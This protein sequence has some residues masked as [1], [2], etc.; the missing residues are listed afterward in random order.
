MTLA[1]VNHPNRLCDLSIPCEQLNEFAAPQ[2][3]IYHIGRKSG[4]AQAS[5]S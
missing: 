4:D 2:I 3:V 5:D 1:R